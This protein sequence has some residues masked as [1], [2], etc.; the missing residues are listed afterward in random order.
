MSQRLAPVPLDVESAAR[1]DQALTRLVRWSRRQV[2]GPFGPGMLSALASVVDDGP[3]RLGELAGREGTSPATLSR[4]VAALEADGLIARSPDPSDRR[5]AFVRATAE[6]VATVTDLRRRR[7]QLL[8][9]RL[10]ALPV[11]QQDALRGLADAL[12]DLHPTSD[13]PAPR[14]TSGTGP[15]ATGTAGPGPRPRAVPPRPA[16]R[17]NR[18]APPGA[19]RGAALP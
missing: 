9:A 8:L 19:P 16:P 7:G 4:V 17:T 1:L 10:A 3:I 14:P 2:A 12:T 5:S 18:P 13:Q 15:H 11:E 6:G